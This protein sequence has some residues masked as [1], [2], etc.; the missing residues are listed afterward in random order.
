MAACQ[1]SMSRHGN[2]SCCNSAIQCSICPRLHMFDENPGLNTSEYG[3]QK[4]VWQ[5]GSTA[6]PI[7]I[8]RRALRLRFTYMYENRHT[9]VTYQYLQKS[10]LERNP[11]PNRKSVILNFLVIFSDIFAICRCHT[12]TNSS[13]RFIRM[14]TKIGHC[15][16]KPFETLNCEDLEFSLE[17][18][19]VASC[20][21]SMFRHETGSCYNSGM[22]C[23]TCTK[24]HMFDKTPNMKRST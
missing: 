7:L 5:N 23:P 21:I 3:F 11:K 6:P 18:V 2:K 24:L 20:Q 14:N 19:S 10:L 22:L 8:Q 12:L 4:Y 13:Q 15:N 9:H 17:G 1:I 16:L